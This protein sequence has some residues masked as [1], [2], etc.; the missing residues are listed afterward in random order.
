MKKVAA[1]VFTSKGKFQ[2]ITS[3]GQWSLGQMC[4]CP[5]CGPGDTELLAQ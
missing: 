2:Q 3:V 1:E 4:G 5:S